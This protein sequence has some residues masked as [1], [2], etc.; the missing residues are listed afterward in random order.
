MKS[1]IRANYHWIIAFAVLLEMLIYGGVTNNLNGLY[2]IPVTETL[3]VS[4]S[5]F[6]L[7][8]TM[9]M[10]AMFGFGMVSSVL[11]LKFG[12]RKLATLGLVGGA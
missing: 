10:V 11:F 7:A 12:F 1:K 5:G 6:S 3:Q 8:M 9:K 4:R 2:I